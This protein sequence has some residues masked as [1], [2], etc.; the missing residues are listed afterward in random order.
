MIFARATTDPAHTVRWTEARLQ[1]E[2]IAECHRRGWRAYPVALRGRRGWPD[3]AVYTRA[4]HALVELKTDVGVVSKLQAIIIREL[5]G[6]V[7]VF[8]AYG[9]KGAAEILDHIADQ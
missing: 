9:V 1:Q 3:V 5:N 2:F 8:V 6:F 7:P 4:Y